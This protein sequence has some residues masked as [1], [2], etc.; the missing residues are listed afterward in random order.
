MSVDSHDTIVI[1][2]MLRDAPLQQRFCLNFCVGIVDDYL[3]GPF[4]SEACRCE[5]HYPRFLLKEQFPFHRWLDLSLFAV[6]FEFTHTFP[7]STVDIK[8]AIRWWTILPT[9]QLSV[10]VPSFGL[11]VLL[12]R[13]QWGCIKENI[14]TM[15]SKLATIWPNPGCCER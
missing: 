9:H 4:M 11:H 8:C 5:V 6:I 3:I 1:I 7:L 2:L 15:Q 14:Y 13:R 12:T 10:E